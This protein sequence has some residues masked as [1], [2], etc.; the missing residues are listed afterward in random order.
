QARELTR[1][2]SRVLLQEPKPSHRPQV[3]DAGGL[4]ADGGGDVH[5]TA[6]PMTDRVQRPQR[7]RLALRLEQ[8]RAQVEVAVGQ[9]R[10]E[11]TADARSRV[12]SGTSERQRHGAVTH[13]G[14]DQAANPLR[15][16]DPQAV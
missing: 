13:A 10:N 8:R 4:A 12:T 5:T 7:G 6:A 11:E 16:V 15:V 14:A 2:E 3:R 1:A 9:S